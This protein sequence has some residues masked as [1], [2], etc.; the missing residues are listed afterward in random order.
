MTLPSLFLAHGAP[1]LPYSP[2]PARA[3]TESVGT[4]YPG[5]RTNL[6][7]SA[8]WETCLPTLGTPARPRRSST[9]AAL[10]T[11]FTFGYAEAAAV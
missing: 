10:M 2:T 4:R 5:L 7:T 9:L 3:F 8:H 11:S 1:A 6:V